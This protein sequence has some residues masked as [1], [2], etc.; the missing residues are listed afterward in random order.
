M[1]WA[2]SAAVFAGSLLS[3]SL[4]HAQAAT[5]AREPS[6][7]TASAA[8]RALVPYDLDGERTIQALSMMRAEARTLASGK[9]REEL[10]FMRAVALSDLWVIARATGRDAL[11]AKVAQSLGVERSA[12]PGALDSELAAVDHGVVR[13]VVGD[14]RQAVR[15]TEGAASAPADAKG[16]GSRTQALVLGRV[17]KAVEKSA[18]ARENAGRLSELADDPC[19]QVNTCGPLYKNFDKVGRRAVNALVL[20]SKAVKTLDRN[21]QDPF[22]MAMASAFE[23]QGRA[24]TTITLQPNVLLPKAQ[25]RVTATQ[26]AA[27]EVPD[28]LVLVSEGRVE[29]AFM[30]R[31]RVN[32]EGEVTLDESDKPT[33]PM[34]SEV[35]IEGTYPPF[36]RPIEGVVTALAEL[37]K[38][39]PSAR[40][41]VGATPDIKG[42]LVARTLL[43]AQSAG[44][45][46]LAMVGANPEGELRT[47]GLELVG[48]L[49]ASEVGPRELSVV[50]RLGGFSVKRQGPTVTIPR[51]KN[52]NG[53]V[54]DFASLLESTRP[55]NAKSAKLTFMSDVAAATLTE[56]AFM[57][58]PTN[59]KLTVVLP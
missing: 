56:A 55:G 57:V 47:V 3:S 41:A 44:F 36:V 52:E 29:Y 14:A 42:H 28:V 24:L 32:D 22:V 46:R 8:L 5:P 58:A 12:V 37:Q 20:A 6:S 38:R 54:F 4:L 18:D 25:S 1:K 15:M 7:E 50:V 16:F 11:E 48:A 33:F 21:G 31:V 26:G 51:V 39:F 30:P 19:P 23:T 17:V 9:R 10:T 40:L 13:D 45:T 53:F 59:Q 35:K 27:G 43:S 49:H 34:M 2:L